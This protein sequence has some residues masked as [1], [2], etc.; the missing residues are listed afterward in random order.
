MRQIKKQ[1]AA[2][3]LCSTFALA[4]HAESINFDGARN[5]NLLSKI[6]GCSL[7]SDIATPT[8]YTCNESNPPSTLQDDV[9]IAPDVT[10]I[11]GT[12]LIPKILKAAS[13]ILGVDAILKGNL[14]SNSTVVL[15]AGA[16]V[17]GAMVY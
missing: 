6:T 1:L 11:M 8:T 9:Y 14:D 5:D 15:G 7:N 10:V 16:E 3:L 13:A 12:E 17:I 4:A 2:T